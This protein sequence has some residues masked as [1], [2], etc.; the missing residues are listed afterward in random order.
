MPGVTIEDNVI[1]GA[2]CIVSKSIPSGW[3]VAGNPV[4][5]IGEVK[6]FK[7]RMNNFNVGTK[8]LSYDDKKKC[9]LLLDDQ[10]F[11]KKDFLE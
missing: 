1:V 6:D 5:K 4:R 11:I 7:R 10:Y 9:L 3:I 8:G 2:G